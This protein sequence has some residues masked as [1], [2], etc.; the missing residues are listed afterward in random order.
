MVDAA[1]NPR[2]SFLRKALI[3]SGAL[4]TLLLLIYLFRRPILRAVG[5]HLISEDPLVHVDAVYVLGGGAYDRGREA[6]RI[7]QLGLSDR[8]VFTGADPVSDLGVYGLQV[9]GCELA[10]RVAVKNGLPQQ[11]TAAL[12]KG[13][14]TQ[15]EAEALLDLAQ[16]EGS[17]TVMILT[18]RFHL[19]RVRNVFE[20]RF[21]AAGIT[22]VLHGT[23]S[24]Y[25][26]EQRWW[27]SEKGLLMVNNEYVKLVYYALKY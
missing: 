15:E 2:R 4:L 1:T 25:Y 13:T 26:D 9:R 23:P 19:R 12:P 18:D 20:D 16:A 11:Y 24:S 27:E 7:H 22:V 5:D 21:K 6:V 14:S 17:D 8:F 10:Q 3:L